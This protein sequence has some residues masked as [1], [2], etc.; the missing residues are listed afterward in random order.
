VQ[1]PVMDGLEATRA[2]RAQE[3]G[4]QRTPIIALTAHA[5]AE[6][7]SMCLEAGMD[8]FLTKPVRR[9]ELE[10]ALRRWVPAGTG[11]AAPAIPALAPDAD[12]E[13]TTFDRAEALELVDGSESMLRSLA[14]HF[15]AE[16]GPVWTRI[17][18]G[19]AAGDEHETR[20]GLHSLRGMAGMMA[21]PRTLAL[22]HD[23][24]ERVLEGRFD[25]ARRAA[26]DL[27]AELDC[28]HEVLAPLRAQDPA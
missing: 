7:R 15:A 9:A 13:V 16:I 4:R 22:V 5:M 26:G 19:I 20:E 12:A 3:H 23:V 24:R 27:R 6:H 2:I 8:D 17:D 10:T 28:V 14:T 18:A 11:R 25:E 1:M 21:L